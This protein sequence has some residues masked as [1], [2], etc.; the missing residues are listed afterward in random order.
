MLGQAD[1][2]RLVPFKPPWLLVDSVDSWIAGERI[3]LTKVFRPDDPLVISHLDTRNDVVPGVLLIELI[4]QA[5]FLLGRLTDPLKPTNFLTRCK[6]H[7][8]SPAFSGQ[9]LKVEVL[10]TGSTASASIC[11]G[12]IYL[13]GTKICEV[14]SMGMS[15]E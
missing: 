4:G 7:F 12:T 3:K 9:E 10:V 14:E 8:F 1:I 2:L 5:G 6:A 13:L 15:V 11:R